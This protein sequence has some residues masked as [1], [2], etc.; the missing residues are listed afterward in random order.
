VF[1]VS[2]LDLSVADANEQ[3]AAELQNR[4]VKEMFLA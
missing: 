2:E 1:H 3:L 4:N